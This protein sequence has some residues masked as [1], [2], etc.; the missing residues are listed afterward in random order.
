L[1]HLAVALQVIEEDSRPAT[2]I[3]Y[4]PGMAYRPNRIQGRFAR[5]SQ[6]AANRFNEIVI[7]GDFDA[8]LWQLQYIIQLDTILL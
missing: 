6:K 5:Q 4:H 1:P 8:E 7:T 3:S 2:H